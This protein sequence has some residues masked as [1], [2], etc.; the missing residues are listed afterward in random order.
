MLKQH[1]TI[2]FVIGFLYVLVLQQAFSSQFSSLGTA[3]VFLSFCLVAGYYNRFYLQQIH[4]YNFWVTLRLWLLYFAGMSLFVL[5]PTPI[6][7]GLFLAS[8]FFVVTLFE[9]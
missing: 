3:F 9:L 7:R 5:L 1:K 8:A 6:F 2:S 4:R